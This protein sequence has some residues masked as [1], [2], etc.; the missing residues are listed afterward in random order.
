MIFS[1]RVNDQK[2]LLNQSSYQVR[3]N[4]AQEWVDFKTINLVTHAIKI[5][6]II[7]TREDVEQDM[8]FYLY[9]LTSVST[10]TAI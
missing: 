10:I 4:G 8:D 3:K 6:L 7:V 2:S 9:G 1:H 5:V